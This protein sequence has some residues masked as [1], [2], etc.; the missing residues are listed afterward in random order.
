MMTNTGIRVKG[1]RSIGELF[2][3]KPLP[4]PRPALQPAGM[5]RYHGAARQKI[6]FSEHII[7]HT[8][9]SRYKRGP[10][11]SRFAFE[12][13]AQNRARARSFGKTAELIVAHDAEPAFQ[14][15]PFGCAAQPGFF[16]QFKDGRCVKTFIHHRKNQHLARLVAEP[17][18][19]AR[20]RATCPGGHTDIQRP[21]GWQ[22]H[23]AQA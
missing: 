12:M 18:H 13:N 8:S 9:F 23:M 7:H 14:S 10:V 17:I 6:A 3:T 2:Q 19:D 1:L 5:H 22:G 20:C 11:K 4:E 15:K 16:Q 21:C